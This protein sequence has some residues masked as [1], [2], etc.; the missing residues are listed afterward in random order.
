MINPLL[1]W[2]YRVPRKSAFCLEDMDMVT[3]TEN[4]PCVCNNVIDS[5]MYSTNGNIALHQHSDNEVAHSETAVILQGV[6]NAMEQENFIPSSTSAPQSHSG[7]RIC[8]MFFDCVVD[9]EFASLSLVPLRRLSLRDGTYRSLCRDVMNA[10]RSLVFDIEYT[11]DVDS[12]DLSAWGT[13]IWYKNF[14]VFTPPSSVSNFKD[15]YSVSS[16][17]SKTIDGN[18]DYADTRNTSGTLTILS[19]SY[20]IEI[21]AILTVEL[22]E[23]EVIGSEKM[24]E[25]WQHSL[26]SN[27]V[28]GTTTDVQ[29]VVTDS[30]MASH[31]LSSR[32]KATVDDE[33]DDSMTS[34]CI[35]R[36]DV[37][38]TMNNESRSFPSCIHAFCEGSPINTTHNKFP[39]ILPFISS[40]KR[41]RC[42]VV[43]KCFTYLLSRDD[44]P[45]SVM[46]SFQAQHRI[47]AKGNIRRIS[48]PIANM[49]RE[50]KLFM[51]KLWSTCHLN[52]DLEIELVRS[53]TNLGLLYAAFRLHSISRNLTNGVKLSG[54]S[55]KS[56]GFDSNLSQ[57]I[58]YGI[59]YTLVDP[60]SAFNLLKFFH[61]LLPQACRHASKMFFFSNGAL[62]PSHTMNKGISKSFFGITSAKHYINAEI[63]YLIYLYLLAVGNITTNKRLMLLELMLETACVW[64]KLGK[65]FYGRTVF[66]LDNFFGMDTYNDSSPGNFYVHFSVQQ[67]LRQ[68]VQLFNESEELIDKKAIKTLLQ[69]LHLT[70][71]DIKEMAE[72]SEAISIKTDQSGVYMVH[73]YFDSLSPWKGE[74]KHPLHLNYHPLSIYHRKV[75]NV[76][77]VLLAMF[78]YHEQFET[79]QF[80]RNLSYY[81]PL[82]TFDS[83]ESLALVAIAQCRARGNLARPIPLLR[84]L[85][86][87]DL[88]NIIF[89]DQEGLHFGAMAAALLCFICGI[90]RVEITRQG[91][92]LNPILPACTREYSFVVHWRGATL[93]T[94]LNAEV[95]T[96]EL[97][98]GESV[99]FIHGPTKNRIHLHTGFR[100]C[101]ATLRL[102]IP[103]VS[104]SPMASLEGAVFLPE[105]L[106]ENFY[107]LSYLAWY[108]IFENFFE[109]YRTL[110]HLNIPP[111]SPSEF[112]EKILYQPEDK[113]ISHIG[114]SNVLH[115]RGIVLDLGSPSDAEI[116]ETVFGLANAKVAEMSEL[117]EK[118]APPLNNNL[119]RLIQGFSQNGMATCIATYSRSFR[120]LMEQRV[121][122]SNF[123]IAYVDGEEVQDQGIKGPP[124]LDLFFF[125]AKKIHVNPNRCIVFATHLDRGYNAEEMAKFR[126][127]LDVEDPFASSR[128]PQQPYPTLSE[129]Y[130]GEHQR[131]NPVV[132]RLT[133][134]DIPKTIDELE[135]LIDGCTMENFFEA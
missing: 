27:I 63:G 31:H 36:Q 127:F 69:K 115:D 64:P 123:F 11:R 116:V 92:R 46:L 32:I 18:V 82:C 111:L 44:I 41:K 20:K 114:V 101:Q 21:Y 73:D 30:K 62:Y 7:D 122:L 65:W 38:Y 60:N 43:E 19:K 4:N 96:Y 79:F 112:I 124:H 24:D 77:D 1:A 16:L 105:S 10:D 95:L 118:S 108:R 97:L 106:F 117:L 76:P 75:V 102:S 133:Y 66:R 6:A 100:Q 81:S 90:G 98:A 88:D 86:H 134:K 42:F 58:Y 110:H 104:Q 131:Q 71:D 39:C 25:L 40:N 22:D 113:E 91:L 70:Q 78:M 35:N 84:S 52:L 37:S 9:G 85:L 17:L 49:A 87:L 135:D 45:T 55:C 14:R 53:R 2:D 109:N 125:A 59:Y 13:Q 120:R 121:E 15:T 56:N 61:S 94:S 50:N 54:W 128:V 3:C 93:K 89:S 28:I 47:N 99:R 33:C 26:L 126:M 67:H 72:A 48:T 130:M 74:C 5:V 103:R 68:A 132:R 83:P 119:I 23:W 107:E 51:D 57:Y 29:C 34:H 12:S 80:E 129:A 8:T